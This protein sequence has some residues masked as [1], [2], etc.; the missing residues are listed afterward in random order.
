[1]NV[2]SSVSNSRHALSSLL[3]ALALYLALVAGLGRV[4]GFIFPLGLGLAFR[5]RTFSGGNF[6]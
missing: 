1:M 3:L 5:E 2:V 6:V 4:L